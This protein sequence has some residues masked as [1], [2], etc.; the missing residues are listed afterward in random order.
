MGRGL[1]ICQHVSGDAFDLPSQLREYR[2]MK[3]FGVTYTPRHLSGRCGFVALGSKPLGLSEGL[4]RGLVYPAIATL[5][6]LEPAS[7]YGIV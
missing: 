3:A 7:E 6:Q 5:L 2:P 1:D 4:D